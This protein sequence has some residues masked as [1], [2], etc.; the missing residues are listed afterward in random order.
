MGVWWR[1][2]SNKNTINA[3]NNTRPS[4]NT[5]SSSHFHAAKE[6][7]QPASTTPVSCGDGNIFP[8]IMRNHA[9]TRKSENVQ[10][11]G[12]LAADI[13]L[14]NWFGA[15]V[16]RHKELLARSKEVRDH[17]ISLSC[18]LNCC[19]GKFHIS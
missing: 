15:E 13:L 6:S 2:E 4:G 1:E 11:L 12:Q 7:L 16:S 10:V 9:I 14:K 17:D 18:S 19:R 8:R 3:T 5:S